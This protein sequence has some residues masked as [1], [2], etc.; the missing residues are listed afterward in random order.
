MAR[1]AQLEDREALSAF[2]L[3]QLQREGSPLPRLRL[4]RAK[5]SRESN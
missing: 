2:R 4:P 5:L 1:R 3:A